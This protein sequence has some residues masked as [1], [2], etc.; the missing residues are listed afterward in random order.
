MCIAL[1]DEI[2]DRR[3]LKNASRIFLV[4]AALVVF[5]GLSQYILGV[6][7]LRGRKMTLMIDGKSFA[8]TSSFVHYNSLGAY[9]IAVMS[10]LGESVIHSGRRF[11]VLV[12]QVFYALA[13][14][15]MIL[16]FSRGSWFAFTCSMIFMTAIAKKVGNWLVPAMLVAVALLLLP[17]FGDRLKMV[18]RPGGDSDRFRYWAGAISMIRAHPFLGTGVGTFMS[19]FAEYRV[20]VK[21]AYVHNCY[22]QI[23]A[24][25]G[26]FSLLCFLSFALHFIM[27]GIKSFMASGDFLLL[28]I[29]SA[30][31]GLLVHSFFEVNLYSEQL[32]MLFW[33]FAGFVIAIS[34]QSQRAGAHA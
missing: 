2:Y 15:V 22:L 6:E 9:L 20:S 17:D 8:V 11:G 34:R 10:I 5:S 12:S 26:V 28:G 18:L 21:E 19:N 31:V 27:R 30:C 7:F 32:S 25:T 33:A 24:E 29:L 16:T 14:T 23:W 13:F 1:Q 4:G 3:I